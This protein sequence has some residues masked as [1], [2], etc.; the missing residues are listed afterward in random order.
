MTILGAIL[1]FILCVCMLLFIP[2]LAVLWV[3]AFVAVP[4][5]LVIASL[6]VIT[7]VCVLQVVFGCNDKLRKGVTDLNERLTKQISRR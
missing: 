1:L 5:G 7:L 2:A 4:L 6:A 3:A